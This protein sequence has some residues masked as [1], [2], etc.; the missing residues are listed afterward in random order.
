MIELK[1]NKELTSSSDRVGRDFPPTPP[2]PSAIRPQE[3]LTE[4]LERGQEICILVP[5][6]GTSEL[7]ATVEKY[8]Q[9][10]TL[11]L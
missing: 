5:S 8:R 4:C 10:G 6:T 9:L 7:R 1:L 11:L 2:T 3:L